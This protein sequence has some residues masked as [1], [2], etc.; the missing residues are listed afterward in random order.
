MILYKM[1]LNRRGGVGVLRLDASAYAERR[2]PD[3]RADQRVFESRWSIEFV[4][5]SRAEVY[6]WRG[7]IR[8]ALE[9]LRKRPLL[10][11]TPAFIHTG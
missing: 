5:R 2:K 1:I 7:G 11:T 6:D 8:V 9:W 4:G 10:M 3:G